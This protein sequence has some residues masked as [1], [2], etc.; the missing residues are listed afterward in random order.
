MYSKQK[1]IQQA[2]LSVLAL[3]TILTGACT[4]TPN[5]EKNFANPPRA[6]MSI[7]EELKPGLSVL[8]FNET[9]DHLIFMTKGEN[10]KKSGSPGPPV[11]SLDHKFTGGAEVLQSGRGAG[12][13]LE[14]SGFIRLEKAG[15]YVFQS[16]SNDGFRLYIDSKLLIDDPDVHADHVSDEAPFEVTEPGWY[17]IGIRYFQKGGSATLQLFWKTPGS[18]KFEIVPGNVLGHIDIS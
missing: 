7:T 13:A 11:T 10:A 5:P 17:W 1:Y 8:Y 15:Q 3:L 2:L 14:L 18:G 12:V 16:N 4:T 6:R 9:L